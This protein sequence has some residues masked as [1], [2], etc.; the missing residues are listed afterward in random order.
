MLRISDHIHLWQTKLD[1]MWI[2]AFDV[3]GISGMFRDY[4]YIQ[5]WVYKN[6]S[7]SHKGFKMEGWRHKSNVENI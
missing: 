3:N 1:S 7:V 5:Y 2:Y 6:C 4:Q